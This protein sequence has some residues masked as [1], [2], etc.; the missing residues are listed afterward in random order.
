MAAML[1]I[2][3]APLIA[4]GG[5][6]RMEDVERLCALDGLAGM[7]IGRALYDGR[8]DLGA[9]VRLASGR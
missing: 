7:I 1:A 9:A 8:V 4:S 3:P 5:V 6:S 2:S